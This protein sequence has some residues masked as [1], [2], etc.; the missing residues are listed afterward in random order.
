MLKLFITMTVLAL[1]LLAG[2][3]PVD[4]CKSGTTPCCS[5]K[6]CK[7]GDKCCKGDAHKDCAKKCKETAAP[8]K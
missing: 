4:C 8:K 1:P 2:P 3:A 7:T 5:E 6:C